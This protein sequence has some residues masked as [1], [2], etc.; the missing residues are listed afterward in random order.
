MEEEHSSGT[1]WSRF[2]STPVTSSRTSTLTRI[3][4]CV[5]RTMQVFDSCWNVT[6]SKPLISGKERR[7]NSPSVCLCLSVCLSFCL[8][9]CLSLCLS[10]CMC[11]CTCVSLSLSV[12]V[13]VFLSL[14]RSLS[15]SDSP[16]LPPTPS[17][18]LSLSLSL[19]S[20]LYFLSPCM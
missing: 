18:S 8:S 9:F 14:S 3:C 19:R 6:F 4:E 5:Q 15:L 12:S 10:R 11:P 2:G 1:R 20:S 7:C 13:S 17:L 16:F